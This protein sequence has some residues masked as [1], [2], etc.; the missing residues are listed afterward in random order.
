MAIRNT[1]AWV[2]SL[3]SQVPT[4]S[5]AALAERKARGDALTLIDIRELQELIDSG[6][7][8]GSHHVPRGMLEFWAD[9]AMGYHRR[10]FTEDAEYVV[11]C[12]GGGRSVLAAL[13]LI[14]MG[15]GKVWHLD[16]G[17][18]GWQEAGLP[19][20]DVAATSRWQRKS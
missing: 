20:D 9:P 13:A 8:P 16:R 2:D 17:F 14:E 7:I 5:P 6:A 1:M 19:V 3:R 18:G 4:L 10:F 15:Y 12:A 11:Y